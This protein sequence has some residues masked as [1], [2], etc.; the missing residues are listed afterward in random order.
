MLR[1]PSSRGSTNAET[2]RM[3]KSYPV[4][5]ALISLSATLHAATYYVATTGS[6]A[7]AGTSNAPCPTPQHAMSTMASGDTIYVRGG[8]YALTSQ[9]KTAKA[10]FATNSCKLWAYSG[11][12]PIFDFTTDPTAGDRGIYVSKDYWHVR[13][14][15]VA[16]ARD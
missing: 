15:V 9:V 2:R 16:F 1:R 7:N 10:G 5:A 12:T 8:T 13:G 4:W 6:D 14:I 11:E 3:N